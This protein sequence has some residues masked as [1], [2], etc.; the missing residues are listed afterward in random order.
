M[1][2]SILKL[3]GA[4]A[5]GAIVSGCASTYTLDNNVQA[6]SSL[7]A[8]PPQPTYKFERLPS[9]QEPG[10]AQLEAMA[11]AALHKAGLRRDDANARYAVQ[12]TGRVQ[13]ILSPWAD[14]WDGFMFGGRG[15][16][17][18][19]HFGLMSRMDS[20]WYHREVGIVVR[21][22]GTNRVVFETH[23]TNDGPWFDNSTV[24][25]AMFQAAMQ[26]FP[27]PPVGPRR[28]DVVVGAQ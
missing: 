23:S 6:F 1:K 15:W 17:R 22:V 28:V 18:R 13:R 25:P 3:L 16:G 14:P 20:P 7:T 8:V 19:G 26:G 10:Q 5:L 12:V 4:L 27:Q 2:R 9:Q 24:F 11:D 21:E